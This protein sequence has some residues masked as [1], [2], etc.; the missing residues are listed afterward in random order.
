MILVLN[1]S[2]YYSI[3]LNSG[4]LLNKLKCN[5][6]SKKSPTKDLFPPSVPALLL[7]LLGSGHEQK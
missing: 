1:I 4:L 6:D 5:P 3:K 2:I 7:V